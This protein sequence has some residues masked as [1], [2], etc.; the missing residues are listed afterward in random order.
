[1]RMQQ[2]A[3]EPGAPTNE[4]AVLSAADV[5]TSTIDVALIRDMQRQAEQDLLAISAS[6]SA[7]PDAYTLGA[8]DVLHIVVWDHPELV[9]ALGSQ[10]Q[11]QARPADAPMGFVIDQAGEVQFPYAGSVRLAGLT[12]REA[13]A[14]LVHAL[15]TVYREPQVT[16]RVSA[17]RARQVY[18]DGEVRAPGVQPINDIPMSLYEAINRAG[19]F[20]LS[21]DQSRIVLVRNGVSHRL[22]LS[23]ML[24]NQ[25]DPSR[26]ILKGGD[27]LR[28]QARDE[29][30][31]YVMGEINKPATA[32]PMRN[33]RLSLS[34][35]LSQAGSLNTSTSDAAKLY[36]IRGAAESKPHVYRL[37]ASSPVAMLLAN[38][39]E[40][41]PQDIV[42]VDATGLARFS[43]I[44]TQLLPAINAG[45]TAAA[46]Q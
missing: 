30:G 42:Y 40:L 35:A 1:M 19:G 26:I 21:A 34:D 17:F 32:I 38:R 31:V 11:S 24:A 6:L 33:G 41:E 36:V 12:T 25:R 45:L 8:G 5:P 16:V 29:S 15:S 18:L 4:A 39:F 20:S 3:T 9:A 2:S 13:Q 10:T 7:A 23:Q 14:R 46:L 22:N 28:V 44:L 43:R 27:V 37:D